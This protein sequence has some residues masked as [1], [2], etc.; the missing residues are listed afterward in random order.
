MTAKFVL[1]NPFRCKMWTYHDRI[2]TQVGE[3]SCKDEI[4]SFRRHGQLIPVLGRPVRGSSDHDV[5]LV[6]GSRRLFVARLINRELLVELRDISDRDAFIAM[7]IENRQRKDI[8]AYERGVSYARWLSNGHFRSQDDIA[9]ALRVSPSYVSRALKLAKLPS[10]IISAFDDPLNIC[11]SWAR[12]LSE[13]LDDPYRRE[14]V[15]HK[16]RRICTAARRPQPRDIVRQLLAASCTSGRM[17]ARRN[18]VVK[19]ARGAP[20]FRIREHATEIALL[21]PVQHVSPAALES[22]RSAMIEILQTH[23]G[24]SHVRK[25]EPRTLKAA[26]VDVTA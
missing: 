19:D 11:E 16:A 20:L 2:D 7:D 5:E 6:Y 25:S 24:Q 8:S 22:I 18:E 17:K 15:L 26:H 21:V 13:A 14:A 12:G 10:V 23:S 4:E 9:R 1:V 3:E